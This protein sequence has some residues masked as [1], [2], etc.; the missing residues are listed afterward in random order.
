MRI[1]NKYLIATAAG[2]VLI[3]PGTA[4]ARQRPDFSGTWSAPAKAADARLAVP[5]LGR[6]MTIRHDGQSL[7]ITRLIL[8]APFT[9]THVLDGSETRT[10]TPARLCQG[11]AASIY[12]AAWD[13]DAVRIAL[14]GSV[15]PGGGP[16][17]K[18]ALTW[19]LKLES[20]RTL[21]VELVAEAVGVTPRR[22][23]TTVYTWTGEAGPLPV[24]GVAALRAN[25]TVAQLD[26]LGGVWTGTA[27]ASAVEERWTSPA[28]GSMLA[29]ART[30]RG[31][32]MTS[33]EF[34]CI[35]ERNEGL[36]YTAMPNGG[37]PA[38]DFVLTKIDESSA[39][40]E[41]PKHDFPK[42]IRYTKR[43]DGTLEAAI[44]G[45][46]KQPTQTFVFKKQQ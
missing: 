16:V 7:S 34:L 3:V 26:W 19:T 12:E 6:E 2:A 38:T 37:Q 44:S 25:A 8:E 31:G 20:E 18:R 1:I 15:P 35:V 11:D 33:F 29:V 36:V 43:P 27:G 24:Q 23:T 32:Q 46:D 13:G 17:Q 21:T 22:T 5:V 9:T 4:A 10:R 30:L 42:M 41:N 39:T 28:G 14:V 40:F 45:D